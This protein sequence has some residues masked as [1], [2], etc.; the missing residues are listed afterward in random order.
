MGGGE[1]PALS[2]NMSERRRLTAGSLQLSPRINGPLVQ[3]PTS[4]SPPRR[5]VAEVRKRGR[6]APLS[7]FFP[8]HL[9]GCACPR[10]L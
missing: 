10:A 9:L 5:G 1:E 8:L 4:R 2:V 7:V 3:G 6:A